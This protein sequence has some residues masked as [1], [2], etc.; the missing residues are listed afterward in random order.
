MTAKTLKKSLAAVAA[1]GAIAGGSLATA[2]PAHAEFPTS[3]GA[4]TLE[5]PTFRV[6]VKERSHADNL[7]FQEVEVCSK[8][9]AG[10][11]PLRTSWEPWRI[12]KDGEEIQ[13]GSYEGGSDK[14]TYPYGDTN[15]RPPGGGVST[16]R[17]LAPGECATGKLSW[18]DEQAQ[19]SQAIVYRNG[20]GEI[21]VWRLDS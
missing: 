1:V 12:A 4:G 2:T 20:L 16:E 18:T 15:G 19:G 11:E 8:A 3:H 5:S 14:N 21:L 10:S 17:Y 9:P 13:A 7:S 6:T